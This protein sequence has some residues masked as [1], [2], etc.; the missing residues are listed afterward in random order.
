MR[1]SRSPLLLWDYVAEHRTAIMC[2]TSRDLFQLQGSNP[3]TVTFV[4]EGGISNLCKFAWYEWIYFYDDS[5]FARFPFDKA[6][7]GRCLG[8]ARNKGN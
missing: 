5:S 6:L 3:Y 4:D 8:P 1:S 7:L 2:L